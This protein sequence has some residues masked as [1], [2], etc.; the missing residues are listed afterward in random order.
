M[1][2]PNLHRKEMLLRYVFTLQFSKKSFATWCGRCECKIQNHC[3]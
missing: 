3:R 1:K 2:K